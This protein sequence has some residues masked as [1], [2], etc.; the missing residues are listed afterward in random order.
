LPFDLSTAA[1]EVV[2]AQLH[3]TT[4]GLQASLRRRQAVVNGGG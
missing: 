1:R 2:E 3:A 4:S